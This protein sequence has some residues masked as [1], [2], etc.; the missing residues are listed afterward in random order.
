MSQNILKFQHIILLNCRVLKLVNPSN[1][2]CFFNNCCFF[3]YLLFYSSEASET[4]LQVKLLEKLCRDIVK[5]KSQIKEVNHPPPITDK[6][7]KTINLKNLNI[8]PKIFVELLVLSWL[9]TKE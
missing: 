1:N 6:L 8:L 3:Q 5:P 9:W 2:Y 4:I 7:I